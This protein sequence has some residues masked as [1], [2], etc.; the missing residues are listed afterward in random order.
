M[1]VHAHASLD[2][3]GQALVKPPSTGRARRQP[4]LGLNII[5]SMDVMGVRAR[6]FLDTGVVSC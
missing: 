3:L 6:V 5:L 4:A 1:F 2:L